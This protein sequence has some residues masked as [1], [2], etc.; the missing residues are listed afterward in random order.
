MQAVLLFSIHK[1]VMTIWST[2]VPEE[3]SGRGL[4]KLLAKSALDFALLNG[5]FLN[6]KCGFVKHYIEKYH[7][8]YAQYM[9]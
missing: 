5:Y 8:Q 7:P 1:Q 2:Q 6:V 4:G 3:L 9:L